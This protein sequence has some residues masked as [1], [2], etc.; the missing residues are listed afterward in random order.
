M[1]R[2]PK[3]PWTFRLLPRLPG[4]AL[5]LAAF[6][7][8]LALATAVLTTGALATGA[9]GAAGAALPLGLLAV[10]LLAARGL[11]LAAGMVG[12]ALGFLVM[13]WKALVDAPDGWLLAAGPAVDAVLWFAVA[14]LAAV[15][16][17]PPHALLAREA[18]QREQAEARSH[19]Q[20][21]LLDELSHRVMNDLQRLVGMLRAE[22]AAADPHAAEPLM[23]AAGRLQVMG[24]LHR[25]MAQRPTEAVTDSAGL[26]EAVVD[27]LRESVAPDQPVTLV[28]AAEPHPLPLAT[29]GDLGLVVN[30]LVTNA[31]KYAF[32]EGRTGEVRVTFQ[33]DGGVYALTVA[34]DGI[35][36]AA[37]GGDDPGQ[38]GAPGRDAGR[39]GALDSGRARDG[40]SRD[41]A[42]KTGGRERGGGFGGRLVRALAAQLGGRMEVGPGEAGGTV[43]RLQFPVPLLA[44]GTRRPGAAEIGQRPQS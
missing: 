28:A 26:I 15:L 31:L 43:C 13:L 33:R 36:T 6:A 14:K 42:R 4:V 27:D 16:A 21:L 2:P 7:G 23:R 12:A 32:P 24:R 30:E 29:A 44:A 18:A 9:A 5:G 1:P 17:A 37:V 39:S 22:A 40:A 8:I 34:D 25:R 11:G 35:G 10:V 41:G 20:T 19:Q 38:A 3:R